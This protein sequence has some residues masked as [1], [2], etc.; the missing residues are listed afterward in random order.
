MPR[1]T[2]GASVDRTPAVG[3]LDRQACTQSIACQANYLPAR[4]ALLQPNRRG[5]PLTHYRAMGVGSQGL[6]ACHRFRYHSSFGSVQGA[7][8]PCRVRGAPTKQPAQ[9]ARLVRDFPLPHR[10][11][12][13]REYARNAAQARVSAR[14][15]IQTESNRS[16]LEDELQDEF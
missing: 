1:G 14:S 15:A 11:A 9:R 13:L 3:L 10:R 6:G 8:R 5:T 7:G 4:L 12:L 16:A 2:R